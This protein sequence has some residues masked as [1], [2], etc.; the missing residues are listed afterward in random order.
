[1][2]Y[3]LFQTATMPERFIDY[4]ALTILWVGVLSMCGGIA[5]Y[6]NKIN[7][8]VVKR[9]SI[10]ELIG[11]LFISGFVGFITFLLCDSAGIDVRI[12]AALVGVSGHM[13][14]RAIF[15]LEKVINK[16]LIKVIDTL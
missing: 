9:F 13:G 1:M 8:G 5:N 16:K 12:T 6:A 10:V 4:E 14:S 11:D 7:Q 3:L 2:P 15:T